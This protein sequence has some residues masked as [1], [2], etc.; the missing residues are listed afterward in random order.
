MSNEI[1]VEERVYMS[2]LHLDHQLWK[3]EIQFYR[4][5]IK[6]FNKRLE[7]IAERNTKQEVMGRLEQFQNH[8]IRQN[9]VID[10]F[11]HKVNEHE[12]H[13]ADYAEKHPVAVDHVHFKDHKGMRDEF[14]RFVEIYQELKRDFMRFLSKY[15]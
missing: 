8:F 9:E 6:I 2:D 12:H 14:D 1:P 7:E 11:L 15:M 10:E 4:E 3:N 13:L 5:E